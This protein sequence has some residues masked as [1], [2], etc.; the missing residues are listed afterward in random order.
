VI[1][2][3]NL[4]FTAT[5][6]ADPA[7]APPTGFCPEYERIRTTGVRDTSARATE[8]VIRKMSTGFNML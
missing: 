2:Q 3:L 5:S 7:A 6:V 8:A 4:S 1:N